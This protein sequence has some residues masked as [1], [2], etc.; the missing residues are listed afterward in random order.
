MWLMEKKL[1]K[2][3]RILKLLKQ[4]EGATN[5]D[6]SRISLNYTRRISDLRRN[7][8]KILAVRQVAHDG[9]MSNTWR[10]Y[11]KDES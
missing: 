3:A 10:Y 9:S 2:P 5:F 4:T 11:L 1:S 8:H 6:L 7:G